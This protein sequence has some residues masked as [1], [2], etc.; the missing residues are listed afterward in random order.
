MDM[1]FRQTRTLR[2]GAVVLLSALWLVTATRTE[3]QAPT[4]LDP[5]QAVYDLIKGGNP[6]AAVASAEQ[7]LRQKPQDRRLGV[8]LVNGLVAAGRLAEAD[9]SVGQ[10]I[11]RLGA[12]DELRVLRESIRRQLA[13]ESTYAVYRALE[14]NDLQAAIVAAAQTVGY[15]PDV[16]GNRLLLTHLLMNADRLDEAEKAA[17]EAVAIDPADALPLMLRG[18]TRQRRAQRA[19]AVADFNDVLRQ[20]DLSAAEQRHYRVIMADAAIAANEPQTALA[21]LQPLPDTLD[22][23]PDTMVIW[24]RRAAVAQ[25]SPA[26]AVAAAA[27]AVLRPLALECRASPYG[28]E[29]DLLP[30]AP[31]GDPAYLLAAEAYKALAAKDN[32][33][34][35][36]NA[37]EAARLDPQNEGYQQLLMNTLVLGGQLEEADRVATAV[38]QRGLTS[39]NLLLQRGEI[40][41]QLGRKTAAEDDFS[42]VLKMDRAALPLAQELSLL[43]RLDRKEEA[44]LRLDRALKAGESPAATDLD[45]AYLAISIGDD[46]RALEAFERSDK[47]KPLAANALQDAAYAS[48]REGRDQQAIGFLSRAAEMAQEKPLILRSSQELA[49]LLAIRRNIAQVSREWGA[50]VS[51]SYRGAASALGLGRSAGAVSNDSLQLGSE[52]YWRPLGYRNGKLFEVYARLLGTPYSRAGGL[53]GA[54]SLQGSV[55]MRL[56]PWSNENLVLAAT[57]LFPVGSL[58]ASDWLAQLAYFKGEGGELRNDT[59]DWWTAQV[60]GEAG[61]YFR[62]PQNYAAANARLG[63]SYRLDSV[64][65]YLVAFPHAVLA[66]DYSTAYTQRSAIG[67]GAGVQLRYWYRQDSLNAHRSY[68]DLSLQYRA[69]LSGDEQRAKGTFFSVL[70][71]Y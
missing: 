56:K 70:T 37:K 68:V 64:S 7:A 10:M 55:G 34:A 25:Q 24:R 35:L 3:A 61:R 19:G 38:V 63:R 50:T 1:V 26:S 23:K 32:A 6:A 71:S 41:A 20:R 46:A 49:S 4:V 31:S 42:A 60:Y 62:N 9:K 8:A 58:T 40:R 54:D 18:Y 47:S 21:L 48:I 51:L 33:A 53:T 2:W 36:Q 59:S 13:D 14:K 65:P 66:A 52:L 30:A 22:Q 16:M 28:R 39:P 12:D 27:A 45:L 67:A 11:G 57:R 17:S 43:S 5:A 44:R 15:A 29:C 69:R